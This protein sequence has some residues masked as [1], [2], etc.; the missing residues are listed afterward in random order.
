M[1]L[2]VMFKPDLTLMLF[3]EHDVCVI[4]LLSIFLMQYLTGLIE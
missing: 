3:L 4:Q 2:W 1:D